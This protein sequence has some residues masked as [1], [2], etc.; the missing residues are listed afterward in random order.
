LLDL[1][2]VGEDGFLDLR[3]TYLKGMGTPKQEELIPTS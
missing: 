2:M 1:V 3:A